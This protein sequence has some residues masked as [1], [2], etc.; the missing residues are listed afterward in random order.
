[1]SKQTNDVFSTHFLAVVL[2]LEFHKM[3][4]SSTKPRA[5]NEI[6]TTNTITTIITVELLA[7]EVVLG[8]G[9]N[10]VDSN[11]VLKS[12]STTV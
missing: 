9:G 3:T 4:S 8:E 2:L 11:K 6:N 7:G 1:M 12:D 5:V 10:E